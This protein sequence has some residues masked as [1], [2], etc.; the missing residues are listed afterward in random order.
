MGSSGDED[1]QVLH[2][3]SG[4]EHTEDIDPRVGKAK[5]RKEKVRIASVSFDIDE[6][7]LSAIKANNMNFARISK[8]KGDYTKMEVIFNEIED[9]LKSAEDAMREQEA[10]HLEKLKEENWDLTVKNKDLE[11]NVK[12]MGEKLKGMEDQEATIAED[13]EKNC[14]SL[15]ANMLS[16]LKT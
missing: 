16:E 5:G 11:N 12:G 4:D 15:S 8:L 9:T 7:E 3:Q 2:D 13:L 14:L 1:V 10:R 6:G